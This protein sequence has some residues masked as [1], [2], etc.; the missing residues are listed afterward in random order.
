MINYILLLM[1]N[2]F[3]DIKEVN[4]NLKLCEMIAKQSKSLE[5]LSIKKQI[6]ALKIREFFIVEPGS[7][8]V[9]L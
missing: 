1:D 6:N 9:M 3:K 4:T 7:L 8:L 2:L 5:E